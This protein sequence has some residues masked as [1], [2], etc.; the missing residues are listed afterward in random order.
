MSMAG[1]RVAV[2]DQDVVPIE[3]GPAWLDFGTEPCKRRRDKSA[4]C[5]SLQPICTFGGWAT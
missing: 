2:D 3:T 1:G 5:K 4:P